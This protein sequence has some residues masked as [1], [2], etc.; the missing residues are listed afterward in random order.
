MVGDH[1]WAGTYGV[2]A[3]LL[4]RSHCSVE[5]ITLEDIQVLCLLSTVFPCSLQGKSHV[6]TQLWRVYNRG[7]WRQDIL[8]KFEFFPIKCRIQQA[9]EMHRLSS[10]KLK[11]I[12]GNSETKPKAKVTLQVVFV[13]QKVHAES[14]HIAVHLLLDSPR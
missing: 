6:Y 7:L 14:L 8:E 4:A 2:E 10:S 9:A 1:R 5:I 13:A 3:D 12:F 11:E